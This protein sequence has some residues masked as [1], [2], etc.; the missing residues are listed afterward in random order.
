VNALASRRRD[1]RIRPA[2]EAQVKKKRYP[3]SRCLPSGD[4][5][6]VAD[7]ASMAG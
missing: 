2:A 1:A 3:A 5:L 6:L 7:G 4:Y